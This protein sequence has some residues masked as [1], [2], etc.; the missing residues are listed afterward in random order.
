MLT[1][2]GLLDV[3]RCSYDPTWWGLQ[4]GLPNIESVQTSNQVKDCFAGKLR[5]PDL[6]DW[7]NH[8]L[9]TELTEYTRRAIKLHVN[10]KASG[11]G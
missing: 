8:R 5:D 7:A 3:C 4:F 2:V 10:I 1:L 6:S 11:H 9:K